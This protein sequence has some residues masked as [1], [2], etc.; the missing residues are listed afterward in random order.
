MSH[1]IV[2]EG[3]LTRDAAGGYGK[4]TGKPPVHPTSTSPSPTAPR[5]ANPH[6]T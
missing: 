6:R 2:I 5:A 3:N 4:D 1:H